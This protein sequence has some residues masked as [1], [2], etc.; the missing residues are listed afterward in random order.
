MNNAN[1]VAILLFSTLAPA[2]AVFADFSGT[3][4]LCDVGTGGISQYW[5]EAKLASEQGDAHALQVVVAV[6]DSN[7]N[8]V[9]GSN[10]A[11]LDSYTINGDEVEYDEPNLQIL[12]TGEHCTD[13]KHKARN[14]VYQWWEPI[15]KPKSCI[16]I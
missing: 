10:W 11:V 2:S 3:E 4:V 7:N 9:P 15:V 6:R 1:A 8:Y 13:D 14:A 5:H 16:T 12:T